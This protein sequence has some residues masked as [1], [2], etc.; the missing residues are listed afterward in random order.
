M[1]IGSR[2]LFLPCVLLHYVFLSEILLS[3]HA[4]TIC[5]GAAVGSFIGIVLLTAAIASV[6]AGVVFFI[7]KR[8]FTVKLKSVQSMKFL[9]L[10][11]SY[12]N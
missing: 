4:V 2:G 3:S 6:V 10:C 12:M 1:F 5:V 9:S 11:A 8:K 7:T